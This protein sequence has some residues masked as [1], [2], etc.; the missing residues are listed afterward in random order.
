M[1]EPMNRHSF[2]IVGTSHSTTIDSVKTSMDCAIAGYPASALAVWEPQRPRELSEMIPLNTPL[3]IVYSV[4]LSFNVQDSLRC[5]KTLQSLLILCPEL[6]LVVLF[7]YGYAGTL[8][9][10]D[11]RQEIQK[12][13]NLFHDAQNLPVSF[14]EGSMF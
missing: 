7:N 2:F 11:L 5:F 3:T 9:T 13:I 1:Y 6:S 8:Y 10:P 4:N 12:N 14:Y